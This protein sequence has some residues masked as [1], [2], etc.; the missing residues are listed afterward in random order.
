MVNSLLIVG[1]P[2]RAVGQSKICK[3][4]ANCARAY[5]FIKSSQVPTLFQSIPALDFGEVNFCARWSARFEQRMMKQCAHS[6][7]QSA[8]I[9][10][11]WRNRLQQYTVNF[12][13]RRAI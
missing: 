7:A 2:R 10:F 13:S 3:A 4:C 12:S 1:G 11:C 9:N 8:K 6:I 5:P